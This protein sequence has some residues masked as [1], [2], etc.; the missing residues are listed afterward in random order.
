ML[1]THLNFFFDLINGNTLLIERPKAIGFQVL[2]YK[3]ADRTLLHSPLNIIMLCLEF[4]FHFFFINF[5][6]QV[7]RVIAFVYSL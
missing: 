2:L 7:E 5:F 6:C 1:Y 3:E 4:H